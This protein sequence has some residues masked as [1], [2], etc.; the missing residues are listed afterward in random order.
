LG[1]KNIKDN[2][3]CTFLIW[4]KLKGEKSFW[5]PY[6][7]V[8]PEETEWL[9]DWNSEE[10]SELQDS[11]LS[12]DTQVESKELNEIWNM[13]FEC[14]KKYPKFFPD[15]NSLKK[16]IKW[17]YFIIYSRAFRIFFTIDKKRYI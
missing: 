3:L 8:L 5:Y 10:I 14:Y 16:H 2:V 9:M 1:K 6:I 12:R 4:E 11:I 7:S 15:T 13:L 17:A